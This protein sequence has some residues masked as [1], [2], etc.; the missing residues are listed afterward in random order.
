MCVC[1]YPY[2]QICININVC[3]YNYIEE[4]FNKNTYIDICMFACMYVC[5]I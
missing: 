5:M 2:I 4:I 1:V 3:I